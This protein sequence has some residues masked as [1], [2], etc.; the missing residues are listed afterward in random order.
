MI[1]KISKNL[2]KIIKVRKDNLSSLK[3]QRRRVENEIQQTRIN[4]NSHLDQIQ[5]ELNAK[6]NALKE[7]RTKE[8]R[9]FADFSIETEQRNIWLHV[10]LSDIKQHALE[11]QTV[12]AIKDKQ[13]ENKVFNEERFFGIYWHPSKV[14]SGYFC[15][16]KMMALFK[17]F[18]IKI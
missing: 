8:N 4:V 2:E 17:G 9:G 11:L 18:P 1:V 10:V 15:H 12:L 3:D 16:W 6:L 5:K 13:K 7:K 14:S